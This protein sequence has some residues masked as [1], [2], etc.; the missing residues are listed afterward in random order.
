MNKNIEDY[1][2]HKKGFLEKDY[3]ASAINTLSNRQWDQHDFTGYE[4]NDPEHGFGWEREVKSKPSGNN[5]PE[6]LGHT[7]QGWNAE[8]ADINNLI[9]NKL[10][11][12]LMEYIRSFGFKWFDGWKGYSIIKFIR[13]AHD[14]QMAE[15]CDHISSLFDGQVKGI[16]MLSIVG[17]LNEDFEGGEFVMFGDKKIE[18]ESGDLIIFP[19]NFMYPHRVDPVKKGT[20]YSYVSWV[21]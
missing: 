18:F 13:Y 11:G 14:Q 21:Y 20:R 12:L 7:S 1:L 10:Q 5:E 19:S 16:P 3:C 15:H 17:Q 6:F 9:I 4:F 8:S 2:F